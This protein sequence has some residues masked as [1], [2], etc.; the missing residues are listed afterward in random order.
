MK[1]R[2]RRGVC[3]GVDRHLRAGDSA[4]LDPAMVTFLVGIGAVEHVIDE[5]A[6]PA[7]AD[8]PEQKAMVE[9]PEQKTMELDPK[10]AAGKSGGKKKE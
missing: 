3:I 7:M 5:P 1:I 6:P 10:P 9:E 4:D 2:A 8:E